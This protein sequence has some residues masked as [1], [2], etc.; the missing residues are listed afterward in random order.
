MP[1]AVVV[2]ASASVG[3]RLYCFGGS[4][5]ANPFQENIYNYVQIYQP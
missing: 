5:N 2:A 4:D 1:Y 3:H